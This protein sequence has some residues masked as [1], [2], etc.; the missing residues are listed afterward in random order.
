MK[1]IV[2]GL[3][4]LGLSLVAADFSQ[5]STEELVALKG[6]VAVEDRDAFRTEMQSRLL[7]MTPEERAAYRTNNGQ[8]LGQRLQDG[9]GAGSMRQ[10]AGTGASGTAVQAQ[11]INQRL[12]D[13]SGAGSMRQGAGRGHSQSLKSPI[14]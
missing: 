8:A 12:Q 13:G 2:L 9:S 14:I 3:A 1:K 7:A 11:S 6:T 5:M 10:G 4:V